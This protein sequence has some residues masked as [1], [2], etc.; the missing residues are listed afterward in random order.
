MEICVNRDEGEARVW[1]LDYWNSATNTSKINGSC[2]QPME[3]NASGESGRILQRDATTSS[4]PSLH[5][6]KVNGSGAV[7]LE[8][9][10]VL[11]SVA[12]EF[13]LVE[14]DWEYERKAQA[15]VAILSP[16]DLYRVRRVSPFYVSEED[17][18]PVD[19]DDDGNL[20]PLCRMPQK[21]LLHG[22]VSDKQFSPQKYYVELPSEEDDTEKVLSPMAQKVSAELS[23]K[24]IRRLVLKR[25]R[26]EAGG[27]KGVKLLLL[28]NGDTEE[29]D[30]DTGEISSKIKGGKSRKRIVNDAS[31]CDESS[32][33]SA[34]MAEEAGLI[35]PPPSK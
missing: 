25:G 28:G 31:V 1:V 29:F 21:S 10:E 22:N 14:L 5:D 4:S 33:A 20:L 24:F 7:L 12:F 13:D 6:S 11:S 2:G 26:D 3:I 32:H 27:N 35:K 17:D 8:E 18:K 23:E 15:K 16:I 19:R 30:V 9:R 34:S